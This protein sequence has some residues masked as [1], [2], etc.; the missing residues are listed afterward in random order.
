MVEDIK[1]VQERIPALNDE[2]LPKQFQKPQKEVDNA[3]AVLVAKKR[4]MLGGEERN[5]SMSQ[6]F[7]ERV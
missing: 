2:L 3:L 7:E 1:K 6:N 4:G 5:D